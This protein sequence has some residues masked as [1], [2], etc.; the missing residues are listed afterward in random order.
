MKG[1][2]SI[3]DPTASKHNKI[4]TQNLETSCICISEFL[5]SSGKYLAVLSS[6]ILSFYSVDKEAD[7]Q[8]NVISRHKHTNSHSL[9]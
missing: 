7:G 9:Y 8:Y 1:I 6:K 5:Q 4:V 2:L 3:I